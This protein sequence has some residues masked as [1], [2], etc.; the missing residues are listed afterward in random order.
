MSLFCFSQVRRE[1]TTALAM[2]PFREIYRELFFGS[3]RFT[4]LHTTV[5]P[6]TILESIVSF[7]SKT[8][9]LAAKCNEIYLKI[10]FLSRQTEI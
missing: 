9:G 8:L 1:V 5:Y 10:L 3:G 4:A 2:G 7:S 6:V